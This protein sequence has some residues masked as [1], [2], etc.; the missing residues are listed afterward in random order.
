MLVGVS[1]EA[2]RGLL[3]AVVE[4][5][6]GRFGATWGLFGHILFCSA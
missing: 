3:E 1:G 4:R 2:F 6:G 5:L